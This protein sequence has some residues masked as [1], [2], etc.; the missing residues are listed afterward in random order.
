MQRITSR[1][2][3]QRISI[4]LQQSNQRDTK[5]SQSQILQM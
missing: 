4:R 3:M 1:E 5:L 2:P